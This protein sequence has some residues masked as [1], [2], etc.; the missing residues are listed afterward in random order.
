MNKERATQLLEQLKKDYYAIK[1][2]LLSV[3]VPD[4]VK[5]CYIT[6]LGSELYNSCLEKAINENIIFNTYNNILN[7]NRFLQLEITQTNEYSKIKAHN[8]TI[9]ITKKD[10]VPLYAMLFMNLPSFDE[11]YITQYIKE[12]FSKEENL[13]DS[14]FPIG[15]EAIFAAYPITAERQMQRQ[16]FGIQHKGRLTLDQHLIDEYKN[17]LQED[18]RPICNYDL[19]LTLNVFGKYALNGKMSLKELSELIS[20]GVYPVQSD[21]F[22]RFIDKNYYK[23]R[24]IIH[25]KEFNLCDETLSSYNTCL[26][27]VRF[28]HNILCGID[29]DT[30]KQLTVN[31]LERLLGEKGQFPN[32]KFFAYK[33]ILDSTP[34]HYGILESTD[35]MMEVLRQA[36]INKQ[37]MPISEKQIEQYVMQNDALLCSR[38]IP[39]DINDPVMFVAKQNRKQKSLEWIREFG[40]IPKGDTVFSY[41]PKQQMTNFNKKNFMFQWNNIIENIY[42]N[43]DIWFYEDSEAYKAL[44]NMYFSVGYETTQKLITTCPKK[45]SK[46]QYLDYSDFAETD[47]YA[48]QIIKSYKNDGSGNYILR[49]NLSKT[50]KFA[51]FQAFSEIDSSVLLTQESAYEIFKGVQPTYCK[52]F[53][54]YMK[55]NFDEIFANPNSWQTVAPLQQE[56]LGREALYK[57]LKQFK[58]DKPSTQTKIHPIRNF[59]TPERTL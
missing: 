13:R 20:E 34:A 12:Q 27:R 50:V 43:P 2:P 25:E 24:N 28:L 17:R 41:I 51:L 21:A 46:D 19:A 6:V 4:G 14:I 54:E 22:I 31:R 10:G 44:I 47:N 58:L 18:R 38:F 9:E 7:Q 15:P 45:L 1:T 56:L 42:H 5:D 39:K 59:E 29:N 11:S 3:N 33:D 36:I 53:E 8:Q 48:L 35:I 26:K 30:D 49:D 23:I 40:E 55:E 16:N 32:Q 52:A 57:A 37:E